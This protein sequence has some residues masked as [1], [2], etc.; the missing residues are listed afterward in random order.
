MSV[1]P[2][3]AQIL[4]RLG[5]KGSNARCPA[6][7]DK[8][9]SLSVGEMNGKTL[10]KCHA[11]CSQGAVIDALRA[12]GIWPP[13]ETIGL[14]VAQLAA[15]RHLPET[16]LRDSGFIDDEVNGRRVVRMDYRDADGKV[17]CVRYRG[18]LGTNG[19]GPR[20]W[21]RKADKQQLFGLWRLRPEP[22]ILVEGETD[23]VALWAAGFNALGVPGAEA[24][25]DSRFADAI[26]QCPIVYVHVEPDAGGEK[27]R[28]NFARSSLR[29]RIKFFT[30]APGAKDPCELRAR[31]AEAFRE[32]IEAA[33]ARGLPGGTADRAAAMP[34]Q[35]EPMA[36]LICAAAITPEPI[37]WLWDGWLA[38]GKL[39]I[40][41][42]APGTGKTTVALA[43]AATISRGGRWPDR[44]QANP[45][46]VLI[47][48][49]E[50]DAKDTLV[51]RL[52]AMGANLNRVHFIQ[53]ANDG[54]RTRSFD[55]A[56]DIGQLR[57]TIQQ[58]GISPDL[59]I[60]DP[61]VSAVSGDSHKG[62]E[63]R[64][65]LQP[66]V[67]LG[68]AE[69]CAVL[70]ISH[71][72]KGTAGR[73]VIER[74]TGS[75]AFGALARLVYA[76]AKMPDDQ[77]GGRFIA[78]AKSNLGPDGGGYRYELQQHALPDH[79]AISASTLLWGE[80][81][82]G[83]ARDILAQAEVSEDMDTKSQTDEAQDWLRDLLTDAP[84]K[85]NDAIKKAGSAGISPKS[86]RAARER[87]GVKP[88]KQ[89]YTGG[90]VWSL[91]HAQD[92]RPSQDAQDAQTQS[93]GAL[94]TFDDRGH[95]GK[96]NGAA[97]QEV[98]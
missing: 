13:L 39:H 77:G 40:L 36:G 87:L 71:F 31:D 34:V 21:F 17:S 5:A 79:P 10:L 18:A 78:R 63:T 47:W 35:Q 48:S 28:A 95:L 1:T 70:G 60:V 37:H 68:A 41:A 69:G 38:A 43:F 57:T 81:I 83:N 19:S 88:R 98:F 42:G 93:L 50:D 16:L 91:P 89:A 30:V 72:S 66:L 65:S 9:G 59:L 45:G 2:T 11:G 8:V 55:P 92:A 80:A 82:E 20:F 7:P 26:A 32:S 62:S 52:I 44:A 6:H 3:A 29:G 56:T 85:A 4:E 14:T 24:W 86:L 12:R 22:V 51:P 33:L 23:S 54:D 94:G 49:S 73:D 15:A 46:Q 61:I 97:D 84:V 58:L 53:T 74:V 96:A 25:H 27:F 76:A 64:R 75:L 67:D 90:W